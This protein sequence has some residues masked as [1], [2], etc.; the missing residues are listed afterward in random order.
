[1]ISRQIDEHTWRIYWPLETTFEDTLTQEDYFLFRVAMLTVEKGFD[2]FSISGQ[3]VQ[4]FTGTAP[5]EVLGTYD[6][7]QVM[8]FVG[9]RVVAQPMDAGTP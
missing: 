1:M 9:P 3:H 2:W 7:R 8:K 5:V 6:A 4:M